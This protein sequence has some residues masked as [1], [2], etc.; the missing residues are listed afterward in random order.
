[1][2]LGVCRRL[3]PNEGDAEDAFQSTFLVFV[4]KASS[5]VPQDMVANWLY[6]VARLTALK[7]K[8]SLAKRCVRERQVAEM[9]E[10]ELAQPDND[11]EVRALIENELS[12]LPER[13]RTPVVLC[14]L[15][16]KTRKQ[17]AQQLGWPEGSVSSRLSRA[18]A[19]LAKRLARHGLVEST[20]SLGLI[21]EH[22]SA[23]PQEL[24]AATLAG[25][26]VLAATDVV[27]TGIISAKVAALSKK[28]LW[29]FMAV[30]L[31]N[32]SL[33]IG[34]AAL[35]VAGAGWSGRI[36][37]PAAASAPL[38]TEAISTNENAAPTATASQPDAPCTIEV[39]AQDAR[40]VAE[41]SMVRSKKVKVEGS[42]C[43]F[44]VEGTTKALFADGKAKD[45]VTL[46][47]DDG[48]AKQTSSGSQ[49]MYIA[50]GPIQINRTDS[51]ASGTGTVRLQSGRFRVSATGTAKSELVHQVEFSAKN[52]RLFMTG[53]LRG[54][55]FEADA[56]QARWD[57]DKNMLVLTSKTD[58]L[59]RM[60]RQARGKEWEELHGKKIVIVL[61]DQQPSFQVEEEPKK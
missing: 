26:K 14:D 53:T 35:I 41:G 7:L 58:T 22:H 55:S 2:V 16:G 18:R 25:T 51:D 44:Y 6:G 42:R 48:S 45:D 28:A 39:S 27:S 47:V 36:M 50:S 37:R 3:L 9:P 1:M 8:A 56:D 49:K 54:M 24:M 32:A 17:A 23:V 38:Q 46:V 20:G 43:V 21:L 12:R 40:V 30:K 11:G 19:M 10:L 13:Y 57:Y 60:R 31:A 4:R 59:A 15:E 29:S 52:N 34:L 5:I 61:Q 33:V